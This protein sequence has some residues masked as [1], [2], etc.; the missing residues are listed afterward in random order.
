MSHPQ[1]TRQKSGRNFGIRPPSTIFT[2][3]DLKFWKESFLSQIKRAFV[4]KIVLG[5]AK[6]SLATV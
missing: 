4:V 3:N 1:G 6:V 5:A 2:G